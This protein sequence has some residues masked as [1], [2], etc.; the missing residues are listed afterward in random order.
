MAKAAAANPTP[1]A[2]SRSHDA[3]SIDARY[4]ALYRVAGAGALLTALLIPLQVVAF[5]AWPL[6]EGGAAAWFAVFR[7]NPVRGLVSYD[8]LILLEEALLIP[9]VLALYTLLHRRSESVM[10]VAAG[11]V[12]CGRVRHTNGDEAFARSYDANVGGGV[13]RSVPLVLLRPE[14]FCSGGGSAP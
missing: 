8:L 11:F 1:A 6:P 13:R 14:Y 5:I 9:V 2:L 7:E 12:R 3:A 10:L 4:A